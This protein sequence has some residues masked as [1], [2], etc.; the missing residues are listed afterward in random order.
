MDAFKHC[1]SY[2]GIHAISFSGINS[3][4]VGVPIRS[5]NT[6]VSVT[7]QKGCQVTS[8]MLRLAATPH[9]TYEQIEKERESIW[10]D[11]PTSYFFPI[12]TRTQK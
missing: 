12:E 3:L 4:L 10:F 1:H 5:I 2:H 9:T 7:P 11:T 8:L 6:I